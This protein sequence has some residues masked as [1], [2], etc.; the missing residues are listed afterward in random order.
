MRQ[1]IRTVLR[2][3]REHSPEDF[4]RLRQRVLRF[5]PLAKR[6]HVAGMWTRPHRVSAKWG[7]PGAWSQGVVRLYEAYSYK[8][9]LV[10]HELGH[11]CTTESDY[12][13]LGGGFDVEWEAEL[14]ADK[15]GYKWGFGRQISQHR[16]LNRSL[17]HHGLVPGT[18]FT[19]E[20]SQ[21]ISRYRVT[22][23]F[24]IRFLGRRR[25]AAKRPTTK[26]K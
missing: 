18:I 10:A 20:D 4:E 21:S 12:K 16:K 8:I 23:G 2:Q 14:L 22:R 26:R 11:A 3:V 25:T 6:Y 7:Y 24:R 15:Y 13:R 1:A 5:V 17:E 9:A 19:V